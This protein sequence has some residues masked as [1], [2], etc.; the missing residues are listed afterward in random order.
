MDLAP[1][2]SLIEKENLDSSATT[3]TLFLTTFVAV[4]GSFVFGSAVSFFFWN[5]S[6]VSLYNVLLNL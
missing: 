2:S 6:A 5:I 3:I 1:E 4:A